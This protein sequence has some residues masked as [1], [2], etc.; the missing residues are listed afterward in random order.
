M[1][2]E[3]RV[4]LWCCT[5]G[6]ESGA[7]VCH[8][9]WAGGSSD[10]TTAETGPGCGPSCGA[11]DISKVIPADEIRWFRETNAEGLQFLAR[12]FG[13]EPELRWGLVWYDYDVY[14]IDRADPEPSATQ[15]RAPKPKA[16]KKRE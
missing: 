14:F 13:V 16:R 8:R 1:E 11:I 6:G 9:F 15:P 7:A 10:A 2:G 4:E 3:V 5:E 12:Y